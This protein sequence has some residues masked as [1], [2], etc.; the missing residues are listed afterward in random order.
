MSDIKKILVATTNPGKFA[1]ISAM[2]DADVQWVG[3]AD[4]KDIT[5]IKGILEEL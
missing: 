5:E 1:E 2:L 3:L 4:F